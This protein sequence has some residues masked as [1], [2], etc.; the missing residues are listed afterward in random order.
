MKSGGNESQLRAGTSMSFDS[1]IGGLSST[2]HDNQT[3]IQLEGTSVYKAILSSIPI[4]NY[5]LFDF[6][7]FIFI[8]ETTSQWG[9]QDAISLQDSADVQISIW[10]S[11]FEIYNEFVYDLLEP[12]PSGPNRKRTT[13][14]LCEDRN[15]SPYVKGN[16]SWIKKVLG[17]LF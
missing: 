13:L 7:P 2:N 9:P 5:Q 14:R 1:G 10:V 4:R 17:L 15:G 16:E 3:S 12:L 11:Y 8:S 6:Q